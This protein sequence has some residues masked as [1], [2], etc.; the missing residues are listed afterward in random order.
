MQLH[1]VARLYGGENQKGRPAFYS[2]RTSLASLLLATQRAGAQFTLLADGPISNDLR[3]MASQA[4]S[5][6]DLPLGP[7]GMRRSFIAAIDYAIGSTWPDSDVVYFCEDDYLHRADALVDLHRAADSIADA[8][9]FAL[10]AST[11]DSPAIPG[12]SDHVSPPGWIPSADRVVDGTRWVNVPSA[13]STFA[14]RIGALRQDRGIFRQALIPYRSRY[15]DHE[16]FLVMQGRLPYTSLELFV[17]PPSTRFHSGPK[18]V[19]ANAFLAPFRIAY[20]AR[21]LTRRRR[22]HLLYAADPN[23]ASH[24]ESDA[25]AP[26]TDWND[27]ASRGREWIEHQLEDPA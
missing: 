7:V 25:L 15:L 17:G 24:M 3:I 26:G 5:I 23:L 21:S 10:Y 19:A 22:P 11:P 4:G 8:S 16:M 14:A 6:V 20:Q 9:Y 27:V 13:T 2:K 12:K 1:V 18:L